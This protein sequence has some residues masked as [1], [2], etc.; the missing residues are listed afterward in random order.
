MAIS[1]GE[2]DRPSFQLSNFKLY[3]DKPSPTERSIG[4][5]PRELNRPVSG[6][7]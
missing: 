1:I 5:Q 4:G 6:V 7:K 2:T 3:V